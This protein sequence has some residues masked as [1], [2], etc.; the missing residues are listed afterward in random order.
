MIEALNRKYKAG[1][2]AIEKL[3]EMLANNQITQEEYNYI[4]S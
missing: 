4:V 3:D 1:K 2:L